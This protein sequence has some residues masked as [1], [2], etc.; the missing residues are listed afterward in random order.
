MN[1]PNLRGELLSLET[2]TPSLRAEYE[3]RI[4]E[5][6][7]K[8]LTTGKRVL[9]YAHIAFGLATAFLFAWL[10]LTSGGSLPGLARAMFGA[11][12]L[13]GLAWAGIC[14]RILKR[15]AFRP[16]SD[17]NLMT[18]WMWSL[19]VLQA[20]VFYMLAPT[21]PDAHKGTQMM[22]GALLFVVFGVAFLLRNVIE[23]VNLRNREEMLRLQLQVLELS[24]R[25]G[26]PKSSD[27][28]R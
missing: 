21:L 23:Q 15:G 7:E 14:F 10:A 6:M 20:T 2:A 4:N 24:E 12:A 28:T 17:G 13:F 22:L 27:S 26:A 19:I 25:I 11:G 9:W 3:R 8:P 16:K 5:M 18:G 1:D